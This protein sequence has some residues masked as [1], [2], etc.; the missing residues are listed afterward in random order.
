M[1]L[2]IGNESTVGTVVGDPSSKCPLNPRLDA[3]FYHGPEGFKVRKVPII[4]D[5]GCYDSSPGF[6]SLW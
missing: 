1:V 2:L 6:A 5:S 3:K 4:N